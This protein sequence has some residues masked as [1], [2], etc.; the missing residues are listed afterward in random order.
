M[1]TIK[2][3]LRGLRASIDTKTLLWTNPNPSNSFGAT[4]F[5]V[6]SGYDCIEIVTT[7]GMTVRGA[8]EFNMIRYGWSGG[9][10]VVFARSATYDTSNGSVWFDNAIK[11]GL[12]NMTNFETDNSALKPYKIYGIKRGS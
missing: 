7:S 8:G 2:E 3:L 4:S 5:N 10:A 12:A 11:A 1:K 6:E 9:G